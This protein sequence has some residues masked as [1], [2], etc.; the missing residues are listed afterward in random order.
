MGQRAR[1]PHD[2]F[3]E[4]ARE[5]HRLEAVEQARDIVR[6]PTQWPH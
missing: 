2:D 3:T 4:I 1:E 6:D 5:L